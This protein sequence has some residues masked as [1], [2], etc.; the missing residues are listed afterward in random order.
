MYPAYTPTLL[1]FDPEYDLEGL[2][3]LSFEPGK[4]VFIQISSL[5]YLH[6]LEM[7]IKWL[8]RK[9]RRTYSGLPVM[10]RIFQTFNNF[11]KYHNFQTNGSLQQRYR[12][13]TPLLTPKLGAQMTS[14]DLNSDRANGKCQTLPQ[15]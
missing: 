7:D 11:N 2:D 13:L 3:P 10:L 4:S 1:Y 12:Y 14:Y 5:C 8:I 9:R 15:S 6:N